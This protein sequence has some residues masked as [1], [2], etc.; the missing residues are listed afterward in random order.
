[1]CLLCLP[2][3]VRDQIYHFMSVYYGMC[4]GAF[5]IG[6]HMHISTTLVL[7]FLMLPHV[8]DLSSSGLPSY[9]YHELD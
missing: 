1:M 7:S 9:Q 4:C 8:F 3:Q 6:I 5:G 2:S